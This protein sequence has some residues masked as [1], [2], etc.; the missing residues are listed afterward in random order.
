MELGCREIEQRR[1][2]KKVSAQ[3]GS[4]RLH[5]SVIRVIRGP[6]TSENFP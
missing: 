2:A 4:S 3:F 5:I 6:S 1:F